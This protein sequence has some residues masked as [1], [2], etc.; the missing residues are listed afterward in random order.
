MGRGGRDTVIGGSFMLS[1]LV[2]GVAGETLPRRPSSN[3]ATHLVAGS[4]LLSLLSP[5]PICSSLSR[6]YPCRA[7]L[8]VRLEA[9]PACGMNVA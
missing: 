8:L 6:K 4:I 1:L 3:A 5:L 7:L 9:M 2:F